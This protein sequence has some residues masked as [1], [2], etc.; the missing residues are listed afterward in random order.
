[1]EAAA[2]SAP[3]RGR[4]DVLDGNAFKA[5]LLSSDEVNQVVV[6]EAGGLP[7]MFLKRL[8]DDTW[9]FCH[10]GDD[11]WQEAVARFGVR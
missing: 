10:R 3:R 7:T 6:R 2:D 8:A 5:P 9:V 4:V 11:D 1:M